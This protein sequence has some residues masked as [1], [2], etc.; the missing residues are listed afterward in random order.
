MIDFIGDIHGHSDELKALLKKLGYINNKGNYSH[1]ERKVLFIGDYIDRGPSIMETVSIVRNMVDAGNAI[2]LMGN[3]E[4]NALC[5]HYKL[6]DGHY[7]REH[8]E[9]N[10]KQHIKTSE[11]FKDIQKEFEETLNWFK[12]LPIYYETENFRAVHACWDFKSINYLKE[13]LIDGKL[14]DDLL[15]KSVIKGTDLYHAI[16]VTLKGKEIV[17]PDNLDFGDKDGTTRNEMRIKWWED[18]SKST[19]RNISIEPL[20][21]LP[22]RLIDLSKLKDSFYY[23]EDEKPIFFGHYWLKGNPSLHR[24]NICCLDY[25]VAKNG[26]LAAYRFDGERKLDISKFMHV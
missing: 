8:S 20:E 12:T 1:P 17:M 16:D 14:T 26:H 7:L 19:Y 24:H 5:F 23:V 9:K 22:N 15:Y 2:A 18:P 6:L 3:H 4:Y 13:V 10:I 21:K 11:Q 25:S